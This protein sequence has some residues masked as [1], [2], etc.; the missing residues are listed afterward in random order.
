MREP[1]LA[2]TTRLPM[3]TIDFGDLLLASMDCAVG[4]GRRGKFL[5]IVSR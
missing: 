1:V 2:E 3:R 4:I 5:G